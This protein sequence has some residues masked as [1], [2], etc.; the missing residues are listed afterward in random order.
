MCGLT[1]EEMK[2]KEVDKQSL[3]EAL[4]LAD[5]AMARVMESEHD[6]LRA[7]TNILHGLIVLC[8]PALEE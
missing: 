3:K 2:M 4:Q 1:K 6:L 7:V 8:E 5:D